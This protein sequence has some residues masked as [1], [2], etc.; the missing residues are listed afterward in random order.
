MRERFSRSGVPNPALHQS[1]IV[2]EQNEFVF[3]HLP[4]LYVGSLLKVDAHCSK[5]IDNWRT[6]G[7]EFT[8]PVVS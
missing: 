6:F 7:C 8:L 2:F 3:R 5:S 1:L 4:I